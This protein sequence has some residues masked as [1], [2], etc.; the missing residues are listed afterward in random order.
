RWLIAAGRIPEARE[1]LQRVGEQN[2]ERDLHEIGETLKMQSGI[3][4]EPLFQSRYR[5]PI[6]LAIS[7][8]MFNQLAGINAILYYLNDIFGR[9]GFSKVSGDIQAVAVGATNLLFTMLAMSVIDR[10]GRKTLLLI[11]SVG[12][13]A[14]L[15]GVSA[16]F[17]TA[18]HGNLLVWLLMGYIA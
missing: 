8:G 12:T 11:G 5:K 10:V 6:F 13:A 18:R 14:C 9:A 15:A 4:R 7:I 1:V 17:F 16:I 2:P 3:R